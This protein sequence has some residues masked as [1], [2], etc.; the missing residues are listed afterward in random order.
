MRRDAWVASTYSFIGA[1]CAC[2]GKRQANWKTIKTDV[3]KDIF[4]TNEVRFISCPLFWLVVPEFFG[5]VRIYKTKKLLTAK[6]AKKITKRAKE[7]GHR[8]SN[9]QIAA[10]VL[11]AYPIAL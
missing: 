2:A 11:L 7:I 9:L 1:F 6:L 10:T 3:D 8:S 4:E 5:S